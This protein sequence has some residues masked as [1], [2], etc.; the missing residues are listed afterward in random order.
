MQY[1]RKS[2]LLQ[3]VMINKIPT[4]CTKMKQMGTTDISFCHTRVALPGAGHVS[5]KQI[6]HS[7]S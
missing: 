7:G 3:E 5:L 6:K 1:F 2:K 4:F